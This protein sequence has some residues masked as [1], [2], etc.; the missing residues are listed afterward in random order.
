MVHVSV[1]SYQCV[2][3]GIISPLSLFFSPPPSNSDELE[4]Q[5]GQVFKSHVKRWH[6]RNLTKQSSLELDLRVFR[7]AFGSS[8]N[9]NPEAKN[10]MQVSTNAQC[11]LLRF[12]V[13][14]DVQ[15]HNMSQLKLSGVWT[16]PD[17]SHTWEVCPWT[18]WPPVERQHTPGHFKGEI[19]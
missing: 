3:T 6:Q 19:K 16:C 1:S 11:L 2:C 17:L 8:P 10:Q 7:G 13:F 5:L 18:G 14:L 15:C 4:L 9:Q 12:G